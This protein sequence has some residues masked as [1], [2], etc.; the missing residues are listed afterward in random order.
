M[1][2]TKMENTPLVSLLTKTST[3]MVRIEPRHEKTCCFFVNM[4]NER[5]RSDARLSEPRCEKTGPRG[6]RPGPTHT[7]LYNHR[8]WLEA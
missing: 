4:E 8:R 2:C 6:F 1:T 5:G 7:G 3:R